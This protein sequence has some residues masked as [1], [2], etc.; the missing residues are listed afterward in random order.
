MIDDFKFKDKYNVYDLVNIL[1]CLRSENGCP[2]DKV[3]TH[4]S[5]KKNLIEE[6]YETIEAINQNNPDMMREELG[7]VLMQVVFHTQIE[8]EKGNFN[9]DD[10]ADENCKKLIE[11]HPHVFGSVN[12][13]G[14]EDVLTNWD[15]IKSKSKGR[16]TIT[17]SI[18]SVPRELP[19]L[20]RAQKIQHKASKAGFDWENIYGALDKLQEEISELKKAIDNNDAENSAEE[21]GDV[22]FSAVNVSRFINIDSEE[23]LTMATDKFRKRF[24]EVEKAAIQNGI[25]ISK[26]DLK[27]LDDMWV[28]AKQKLRK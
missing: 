12:V 14:V 15:Q 21:L 20:M 13:N 2:W 22:I 23:A 1:K 19:A 7:D 18:D 5:I 26:T 16:K 8:S 3:Q 17:D 24:A 6:T 28:D 11:R 4:E 25:D 27:E 9:L 10:V